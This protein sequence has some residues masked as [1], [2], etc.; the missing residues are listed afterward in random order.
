MAETFSILIVGNDPKLRGE[1]ADALAGVAEANIVPHFAE[2]PT[3]ALETA[4]ALSPALVVADRSADGKGFRLLLEEIPAAAPRATVAVSF[5]PELFGPDDSEA[6]FFIEATRAGARDFLR[7]PLSS[8]DLSQLLVRLNRPRSSTAA[9]LGRVCS[10]VSNKGGVGKSTLAV[11]TACLLAKRHPER[12]LLID[13]SLQ[14]GVCSALL[15]L[16]PQTTLTNAARERERL[17]ET[18]LRQLAVRHPCGLELLACPTDAEEAAGVDD[19]LLSRVITLARRCYDHIVIDTFPIV[20]RVILA[21]L[22]LSDRVYIVLD[23]TVPTILGTGKLL[24]LMDRL[25]LPTARQC[26]VMNRFDRSLGGPSAADVIQRLSRNID[27]VLPYTKKLIAAANLGEPYALRAWSSWGFGK[28]IA[29]LT[30]DAE[31]KE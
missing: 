10:F 14:M 29:G 2:S 1:F 28:A 5:R 19:Q 24:Q 3:A 13:A 6:H 21:V 4:R 20:D 31:H 8:A 9:K 27:F 30:D 15:N 17:D 7:R 12:V 22:D 16:Q 23:N 25:N 26:I 18:L 11:S